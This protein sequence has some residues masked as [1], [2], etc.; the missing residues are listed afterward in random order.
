MRDRRDPGRVVDAWHSLTL[1]Q[2]YRKTDG[3]G[4]LP[5][6]GVANRVLLALLMLAL[7]IGAMSVIAIRSFSESQRSFNRVATQQLAAI[8]AAAEL[9]QR[10]EAL[11]SLA[12]E[13]FAKGFD[14]QALLNFSMHS[15]KEQ[16][17]LQGLIDNLKIQSQLSVSEV[18]TAKTDLFQN[19]DALATALYERA[20]VEESFNQE[21]PDPW[22][23]HQHPASAF[24]SI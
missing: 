18:E 8:N 10:A 23:R 12:P 1:E 24:P 21:E 22:P 6:F 3:M 11:T 15:Y 4:I 16:S 17:E 7:M 19:L 2:W 5:K 14:Q 13:L 9:K 20:S